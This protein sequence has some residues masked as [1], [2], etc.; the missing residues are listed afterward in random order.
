MPESPP[1][2]RGASTTV[3]AMLLRAAPRVLA[4]AFASYVALT[5]DGWLRWLA[6]FAIVINV[7]GARAWARYVRT[8]I[9]MGAVGVVPPAY[10]G[11]A[12][13]VWLEAAGERRIEVIKVVR[14]LSGAGL[15]QAKDLVEGAPGQ[16]VTGLTEE[17]AGWAAGRLESAG[18]TASVRAAQ[19]PDPA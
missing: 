12:H 10:R 8:G 13:A 16:V 7:L 14:E 9:P 15:K 17:G 4:L 1:S 2:P 18:A 11:G 5:A 19:A 3:P 6:V